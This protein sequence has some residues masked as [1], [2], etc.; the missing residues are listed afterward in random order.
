MVEHNTQ[1]RALA[2]SLL[3]DL[4]HET[5]VAPNAEAA[6][7]VLGSEQPI[8]L[9]FC[10][11]ALG[12]PTDGRRLAELARRMRPGLKVLLTSGHPDRVQGANDLPIIAKPYQQSDLV[13]KLAEFF[14]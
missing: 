14:G 4:G 1:V 2:Q 10:D 7:A 11:L 8:D 5:I 6:L 9:L 3:E 12:G 13:S